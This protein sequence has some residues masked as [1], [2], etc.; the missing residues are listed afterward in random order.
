MV[1]EITAGRAQN[2]AMMAMDNPSFY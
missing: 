1:A 2:A